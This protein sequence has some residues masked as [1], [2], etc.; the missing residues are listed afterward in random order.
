MA[1]DTPVRAE[2]DTISERATTS[3]A[4]EGVPTSRKPSVVDL[5][6]AFGTVYGPSVLLNLFVAAS[7]ATL[8]RRACGR[9]SAC[10]LERRVRPI[11]GLGVGM[12]AAYVIAIRPW[13]RRWGAT[14][15][16]VKRALP[17]DEL[18]PDPAINSTWSV[19]IDAPVEA[20]WPW[21]AQIGQDRGGFYSYAWLENL[22]GC[23][24]Q[25]AN[26][27]HPEWQH[28]A[29]GE[30]VPLHPSHGLPLARFEPGHALVL[31]GWGAFVVEPLDSQRTRLISRT[32]V[33]K[34]WS[35]IS[36]ALLME[37]P[38][39]IMQ[40][41][42]LLEIKARAERDFHAPRSASRLSGS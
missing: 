1:T 34:G 2:R 7:A 32:R 35:A 15:D 23:K 4:G 16:E 37:L 10:V 25:N 40:R 28:R 18:V 14:D 8:V 39:F 6:R 11:A 20:V 27:V 21:L 30:I 42:M 38:H 17:G 31:D 24:L 29:V 22:A 26:R 3:N 19:T 33:R 36:Y 13:L 12:A 9:G 41:E 5:L